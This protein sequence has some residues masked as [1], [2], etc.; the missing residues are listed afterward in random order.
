MESPAQKRGNQWFCDKRCPRTGILLSSGE[1]KR[2]SEF[3]FFK[4]HIIKK[5]EDKRFEY[6]TETR[7][8]L[9]SPDEVWFNPEK[10]NVRTYLKHYEQGTLKLVVDDKLEAVTMY[11]IDAKHEGELD[12]SRKGILMYKN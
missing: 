2:G 5:E 12:K 7:N 3:G 8:I 1:G 9:T 6:A 11:Q 10:K 4:N